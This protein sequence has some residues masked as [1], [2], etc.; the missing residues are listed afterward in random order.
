MRFLVALLRRF[1]RFFECGEL[2]AQRRDLLVQ[3]LDLRQRA[4]RD[5]LFGI[6]RLVQFGGAAGGVVAGA[7]QAFIE[8]LDAI[9]FGLR[10][11]EPGA[12]LRDRIFEIDLAEFFHR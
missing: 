10:G 6:Q 1:E 9:A 12:Q 3:Y 5:H 2:A 7:G 4:R 11:G 8:A